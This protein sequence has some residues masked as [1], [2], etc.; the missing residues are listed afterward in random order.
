MQSVLDTGT[1]AQLPFCPPWHDTASLQHLGAADGQGTAARCLAIVFEGWLTRT[2]Q[3]DG[4]FIAGIGLSLAAQFLT[5]LDEVE[6]NPAHAHGYRLGRHMLGSSG[7][8]DRD[9]LFAKVQATLQSR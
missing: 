1:E 8:A 5:A 9:D 7:V 2:S 4:V 6:R 3:L